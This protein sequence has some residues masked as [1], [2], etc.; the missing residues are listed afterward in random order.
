[1]SGIAS[2]RF[3]ESE[4][5]EVS[6]LTRAIFSEYDLRTTAEDITYE[7]NNAPQT[8]D[9]DVTKFAYRI[10]Y[11][12]KLE[13]NMEMRSMYQ[14]K[15]KLAVERF[16]LGLREPDIKKATIASVETDLS[17]MEMQC[18]EKL[19]NKDR[20]V[21]RASTNNFAD[22]RRGASHNNN[23]SY[24]NSRPPNNYEQR[25]DYGRRDYRPSTMG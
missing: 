11:R 23:N 13:K 8:A 19:I 24:N 20:A 18:M 21:N 4:I 25:N 1:M 10:E 6:D 7:L 16:K 17:I 5:D 3:G 14:H 15:K 9:E 12:K 22:K 2:S